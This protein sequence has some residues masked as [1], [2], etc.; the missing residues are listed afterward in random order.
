MKVMVAVF[1]TLLALPMSVYAKS[2]LEQIDA[3]YT[4]EQVY[5]EVFEIGNDDQD[6]EVVSTTSRQV[7][8]QV[9]FYGIVSPPKEWSCREYISGSYYSGTLTLSGYKMTSGKTIATYEGT[10]YK[11]E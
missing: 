4:T 11:E 7:T 6:I 8:R 2:T 10:L 3:G 9:T 1:I 5:Y